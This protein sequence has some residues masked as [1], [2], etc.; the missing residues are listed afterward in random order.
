MF[1]TFRL[2]LATAVV[3]FH[4]GVHAHGLYPGIAAVICFLMISG[5]AMSGLVG[6]SFPGAHDAPR[7]YLDRALRLLPQYE[8]YVALGAFAMFGLGWHYGQEQDGPVSWAGALANLT[9]LPL[10]FY[11][12]SDAIS[13]F[14]IVPQ[15]WSLGLEAGFYLILPWLLRARWT[16]WGALTAAAVVFSLATR[17]ALDPDIYGYRLL[18]AP[19]LW[20]IAGIALQRRQWR[21]YS[22]ICLF[23]VASIAALLWVGRVWAGFNAPILLGAVI[24]LAVMPLLAG[25][26][27]RGWDDWCGNIS[28]GVYL[29][30]Y[31]FV[32]RLHARMDEPW[33]VATVVAAS[34]VAGWASWRLV[35]VP[36]ARLRRR[37]R[38]A[39]GL[40]TR[41]T[42]LS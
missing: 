2:L 31:I 28:Y 21:L 27:R 19:L 26:R 11:M 13:H 38:L 12:F 35:E 18:P 41:R 36:V 33:A 4:M 5:Y 25:L 16:M 22:C 14:M 37:N 3:L 6:A 20:F 34:L 17:G 15:A 8:F 1:G 39:R 40:A 7:F 32:A 9:L 10:G 42:A 29:S 24:G 30:H 23:T